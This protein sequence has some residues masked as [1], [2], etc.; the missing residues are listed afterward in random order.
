MFHVYAARFFINDTWFNEIWID[1]HYELK[2]SGSITDKLILELVGQLNY[3]AFLPQV[4]RKDGFQFF[5]TSV[6]LETKPYRLIWVVPPD[7]SYLG[8]RNAYRRSR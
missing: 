7:G 3:R 6:V 8:V 1:S 5:E 4:V 2:H